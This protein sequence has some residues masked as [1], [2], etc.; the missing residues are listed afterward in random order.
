MKDQLVAMAVQLLPSRI[1]QRYTSVVVACLKC[2]DPGN[3]EFGDESSLHDEDEISIGVQYMEKV[4]ID[5]KEYLKE[6]D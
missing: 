5:L 3:E 6:L 4:W 2:L 1:G